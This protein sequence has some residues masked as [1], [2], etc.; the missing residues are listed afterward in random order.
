MKTEVTFDL[1]AAAAPRAASVNRYV[2]TIVRIL[3]GL[4]LFVFGLNGFFNFFPPP[5][6]ALPEGATAFVNALTQT[7]YMLPLIAATHTIVGALLLANRFVPLA[8]AL[9]APFM[10]HSVAFHIFLERNG[11]VM[12][13]VFLGLELYLVWQYRAAFRPMLAKRAL[14]SAGTAFPS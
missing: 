1:V 8:L 12:S 10:V 2:P 9:F 5:Q 14:P 11:L 6:V 7:G 4:P 3:L 13:L